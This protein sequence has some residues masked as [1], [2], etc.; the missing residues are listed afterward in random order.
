VRSHAVSV[1]VAA[2]EDPRWYDGRLSPGAPAGDAARSVGRERAGEPDFGD[3][4][5]EHTGYSVGGRDVHA[6]PAG[7]LY[8]RDQ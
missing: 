2:G 4:Y 8:E 5:A 1:I 6:N 3:G 7:F